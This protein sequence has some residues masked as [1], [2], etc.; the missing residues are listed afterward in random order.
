MKRLMIRGAAASAL[1]A[2]VGLT[3]VGAQA[4][5]PGSADADFGIGG[6]RTHDFH[7]RDDRIHAIKP[8]KNGR[9]L[10]A[11]YVVGPNIEGSGTSANFTV[12]RFLPDGRIDAGFGTDGRMELD[13]GGGVDHAA[14]ITT[15]PDRSIIAVG[16]LSP[17]FHSDLAI[18]KITPNGAIDTSFG[19]PNGQGGRL[20]WNLLDLGGA[21]I[22]D[23]GVAVA[24]QST[25][26][27]VVAGITQRQFGNF[28]YRRVAVARFNADGSIDTGF[29]G[30]NTGYVVLEPFYAGDGGDYATGFALDRR[31]RLPADDRITV[32]GYTFAR[33][34]AF[35]ARLT[36]N[37][38]VDTSFGSAGSGRVTFSSS[39]SGGVY[40]GLSRISAARLLPDGKIAL[41]GTAGDRGITFMRLNANGA[42]DTSFGSNGRTTIKYS[43]PSRE[44]EPFALAVQ[45]NGRLVAAGYAINAAT[46]APQKDF[47][48]ARVNANGSPD[49]GF[50]DG[51]A[52]AVVQV[53]AGIDEA[54]ALAVEP[55]G[56]LLA[57]GLALP[58][59]T[60]QQDFAL[61]R[62]HGD[63]DRIFFHDFE[64]PPQ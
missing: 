46:G 38:A 17:A 8:L 28:M 14:A 48:L 45:G 57:G 64:L 54:Y 9:F 59:G 60:A 12:A 24:V 53:V 31:D 42:L 7:E 52:R 50:G 19:L 47:F 27:I 22:H 10:A 41:A 30:G 13:I 6:R 43:D 3:S 11:G 33:N 61:L 5:A 56:K 29:G 23:D 15:L 4:Q 37:G 2:F 51:Q 16:N 18:V 58:T 21:N 26:K 25:G 62:L 44:D 34:T 39:V 35:I 36:A 1:A 55:S 40:S 63:P 32:V 20:G 49:F